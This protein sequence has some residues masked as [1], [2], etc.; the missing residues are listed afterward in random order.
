MTYLLI[1]VLSLA[2]PATPASKV[3]PHPAQMTREVGVLPL[4]DAFAVQ[5]SGPHS[6]LVERALERFSER[7]AQD[8]GTHVCRGRCQ[9]PRR[10]S[11]QWQHHDA[12]LKAPNTDESYSLII[13][14]HHAVL[15]ASEPVGILRGL[16]TLA[17]WTQDVH[18]PAWPAVRIMDGPR[19]VWRGLMLDVARHY[20]PVDVIKRNLD[21]M[22]VVKMN[23]LHWHLTDDQGFRVESHRF[24]ELHRQGSRG[25]YYTR[26]QIQDIVR[27][28]GDRGIRVVPEFDM[29]GHVQ[30]WLVSHPEL[31]THHGPY[32]LGT[33]WGI[34]DAALDPTREETYIFLEAF[35]REMAG[36][37]PDPYIHLGGDEVVGK[38]W[39]DSET[40]R[41]F[42]QSHH[43]KGTRA[44]QAYF[45]NRVSTIAHRFGKHVMGW[46]DVLQSGLRHGTVLESWRGPDGLAQVLRAGHDGVLAE[47]Y[48][49]DQGQSAARHYGRDPTQ[50]MTLTPAEEKHLLGGEACVW[51]ELVRPETLDMAVWPR[52]GAIAERFWSPA[53]VNDEHDM[54]RRLDALSDTLHRMGLTH[55]SAQETMLTELAGTPFIAPLEALAAVLEPERFNWYPGYDACAPLNGLADALYPESR[56]SYDINGRVDNVLQSAG[57]VHDEALEAQFAHLHDIAPLAEALMRRNPALQGALP[58][59]RGVSESADVA[60]EALDLLRDAPPRDRG[61]MAA[62]HAWVRHA[63][64]VLDEAE[65]RHAGIRIAYVGA[66]RKLVNAVAARLSE[67]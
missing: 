41:A 55:R 49:L 5:T 18:G 51:T 30:S 61:A 35:L 63:E 54:Y 29:P 24:P 38:Q 34:Y 3:L 59:A 1:A 6:P 22:A 60:L 4:G 43:L 32:D 11:V 52:A 42:M 46:D 16:E 9:G 53:A 62:Q 10:L 67:A 12:S 47:G 56:V 13:D 39:A 7:L 31:S 28:A 64:A 27:Y 40:V 14:T 44:L 36:L 65:Q 45:F 66:V 17:M 23:V 57:L 21:A 37:F 2:A 48:Y 50:G 15:R 58:V 20:M 33:A 8:Y 26:E 25:L 19:F